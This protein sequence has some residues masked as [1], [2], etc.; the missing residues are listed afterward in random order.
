MVFDG[1]QW[2]KTEGLR[3]RKILFRENLWMRKG[4]WFFWERVNCERIGNYFKGRLSRRG[5]NQILEEGA[6]SKVEDE[7]IRRY[8]VIQLWKKFL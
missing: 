6:K 5:R 1:W 8:C 2:S 4:G 7:K 3:R